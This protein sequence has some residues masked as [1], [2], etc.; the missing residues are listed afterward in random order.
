MAK[1][2]G[3]KASSVLM[4]R[5]RKG[6]SQEKGQSGREYSGL[7]NQQEKMRWAEQGV[8]GVGA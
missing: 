5:I 4:G 3:E 2:G 6:M 8:R 1:L 7:R